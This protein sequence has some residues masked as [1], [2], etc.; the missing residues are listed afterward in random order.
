[1]RLQRLEATPGAP[2]RAVRRQGRRRQESPPTCQIAATTGRRR[3]PP[4]PLAVRGRPDCLRQREVFVGEGRVRGV[5]PRRNGRKHR[6]SCGGSRPTRSRP[7]A[8]RSGHASGFRSETQRG[9]SRRPHHLAAW[10]RP[11]V[12][13]PADPLLFPS[14]SHH[15]HCPRACSTHPLH[16]RASSTESHRPTRCRRDWHLVRP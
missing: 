6:R 8:V 12:A 15:P 9:P 5:P 7:P 4:Q 10:W 2:M 16:C 11:S 13:S 14:T 1:M 3:G